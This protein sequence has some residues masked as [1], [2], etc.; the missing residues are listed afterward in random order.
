MIRYLGLSVYSQIVSHL[1]HDTFSIDLNMQYSALQ[2][3]SENF[4]LWD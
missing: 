2:K 3:Q 4:P 1:G